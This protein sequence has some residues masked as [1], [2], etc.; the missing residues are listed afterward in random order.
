MHKPPLFAWLLTAALIAA[1]PSAQQS[2]ENVLLVT[3]DGLRWQE[4]FHGAD[5]A[6]LN[7]EH[8]GV[9]DILATR[10]S[11]WRGSD[12]ARRELLLPFLWGTV[13]SQGQLFGDPTRNAKAVVTNPHRFSYPGY[14]EL[15]S[16]VVDARIDSN[17]KFPNP[18]PTVLSFLH[19]K[20]AYAD[21]VAA[22][23][24]WDVHEYICDRANTGLFCEVAWQPITVARDASRRASL[25]GMVDRLP[26]PWN[27][28]FCFD[29]VTFARAF[30]YLQAKRPR[31]LY[32]AFGETDEWAH[33]R[34]YDLYLQMAQRNDRMIAQLWQWLQQ[35]EQ[36]AG[37]TS[38]VLTVDHGR[39]RTPRD[40]TDH[41]AKVAGA[42]AV[43]MAV[44]GPDTQPLGVRRDVAATQAMIAST[45]AS[46][47]GENFR[48]V[49]PEAAA[50]LPGVVR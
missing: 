32:V 22:F 35:D 46:L 40:W 26:R 19:G 33:A 11:F 50:A 5:N 28:G 27:E 15:L 23:S 10:R 16:G 3:L 12:E 25:Q 36:Y 34:R 2:T 21:K 13:A 20:P 8:G 17:R 18:R 43:W 4:V 38:L 44:L 7:K 31:V 29:A 45:V 47:L 49:A 37:K 14:G 9:R 24:G 6:M 42:D 1:T 30:E 41:G 39:G 48:E